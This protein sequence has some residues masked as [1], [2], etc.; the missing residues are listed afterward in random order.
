MMGR[1]IRLIYRRIPNRILERYDEVIADLGDIIVAR[2]RFYGMPAP[3][4]VDGIKV[5]ENGNGILRLY[6]TELRYPKGL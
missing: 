3:L 5:I 2:S 6:R 1:K 4:Y